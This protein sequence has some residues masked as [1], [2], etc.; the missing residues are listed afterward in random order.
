MKK[1]ENKSSVNNPVYKIVFLEKA[2]KELKKLPSK[3]STSIF[4]DIDSLAVTPYPHGFKKLKGK[5]NLYRIRHGDYR[6]VYSVL[7]RELV[8]EVVRV[9][10][11]KDIYKRI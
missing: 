11:R 9:A 4:R 6:V 7:N 10:N 1:P 8:I 5:D 2:L 3:I